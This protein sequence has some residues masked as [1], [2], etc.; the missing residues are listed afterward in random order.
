MEPTDYI[1]GIRAVIEAI[2]EGRSIDKLFI[3]KDLSGDLASELFGLMREH[4]I[5]AQRVPAERLNR[6]TRKNHQGVIALLPAIEYTNLGNLVTSLYDEGVLPFIVVLDGITDVRNF[7]AIARTAECC[8]VNA[9]CHS[10]ARQRERRSR[11]HK[12]LCRRPAQHTRV[13]GTQHYRSC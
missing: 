5:V 9:L 6:I 8:G 10:R 1:Y 2:R 3:K 4:R 7:G 11:C 13:Q 12:D